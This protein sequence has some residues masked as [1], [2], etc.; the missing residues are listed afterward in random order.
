MTIRF[1]KALYHPPLTSSI[2]PLSP[3]CRVLSP[4]LL[5]SSISFD[6]RMRLC[7]PCLRRICKSPAHLFA[8][9]LSCTGTTP[10]VPE[11]VPFGRNCL[12]PHRAGNSLKAPSTFGNSGRRQL[13][14]FFGQVPRGATPR[15][16]EVAISTLVPSSLPLVAPPQEVI[17]LN[18]K[19]MATRAS[20]FTKPPLPH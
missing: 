14:T 16:S 13:L 11:G 15:A 17:S 18:F 3:R 12:T 9:T 20:L 7:P 19:L 10:H 2:L 4:A 1:Q 5:R 6:H 8:C